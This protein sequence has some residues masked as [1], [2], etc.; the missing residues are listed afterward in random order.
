VDNDGD[1]GRQRWRTMTAADDEARKIRRRT[2][3][4]KDESGRQEMVETAER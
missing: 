3:T 4:G 2:M 1:A